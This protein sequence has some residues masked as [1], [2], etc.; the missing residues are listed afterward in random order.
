MAK[1]QTKLTMT[2]ERG[3]TLTAIDPDESVAGYFKERIA[4]AWWAECKAFLEEVS[5]AMRKLPAG[6]SVVIESRPIVVTLEKAPAAEPQD[7]P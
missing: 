7:S 4:D 1:T 5:V 3:M 6:E 2:S